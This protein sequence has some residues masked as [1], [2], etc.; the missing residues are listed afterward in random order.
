MFVLLCYV[1]KAQ[2]YHSDLWKAWHGGQY[3]KVSFV[4]IKSCPRVHKHVLFVS[5]LLSYNI[6]KPAF[7]RLLSVV[8]SR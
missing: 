7:D 5:D 1:Y 2:V 6:L 3:F 8:N 4:C